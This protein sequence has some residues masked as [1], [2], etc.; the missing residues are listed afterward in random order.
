MELAA[1]GLGGSDGDGIDHHACV[2]ALAQLRQ[3]PWIW[4]E[5]VD[6]GFRPQRP[7]ALGGLPDVRADVEDRPRIG[8]EPLEDVVARWSLHRSDCRRSVR[9]SGE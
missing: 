8:K 2:R 7:E 3:V 4:L 1:G 5:A 9:V 6:R